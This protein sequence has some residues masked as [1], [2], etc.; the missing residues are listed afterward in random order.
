MAVS[1]AWHAADTGSV[2]RKLWPDTSVE[3]VGVPYQFVRLVQP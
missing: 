1:H 2:T 3:C